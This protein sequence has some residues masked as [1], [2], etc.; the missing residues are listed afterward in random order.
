M[1]RLARRNL[2]LAV[3]SGALT[4]ALG[5]SAA[6][7]TRVLVH[8]DASCGCCGKWAER[9]RV[10]GYAVEIRNEPD[11]KAV[12]SRLGVPAELA[13]C[14]TAEID[15]YVVEGHAPVAAI[16]RILRE[17]PEAKGLAVPGMPA[18][19]PGMETGAAAESYEVVLFGPAGRRSYGR[20]RGDAA[21]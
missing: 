4:Q 12:K 17:R 18:G 8:R 13:S 15:G 16:E 10:A 21:L 1:I 2:L 9:L 19:S 3:A 20:F 11:M 6:T 5:A 14:H 7:P